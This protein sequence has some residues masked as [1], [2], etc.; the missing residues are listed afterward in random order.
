MY[1][2]SYRQLTAFYKKFGQSISSLFITADKYVNYTGTAKVSH[3]FFFWF[4]FY[5]YVGNHL[6]CQLQYIEPF[7]LDMKWPFI[8]LHML[9]LVQSTER[10]WYSE[11]QGQKYIFPQGNQRTLKTYWVAYL[12]PTYEMEKFI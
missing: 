12:T 7:M 10:Q 9:F 4:S 11:R 5:S 3:W 6:K 2:V 8:Q 1:Y